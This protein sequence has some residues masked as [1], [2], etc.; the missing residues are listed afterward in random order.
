MTCDDPDCQKELLKIA[1]ISRV[2]KVESDKKKHE[3]IKQIF[4][5][6]TEK[7]PGTRAHHPRIIIPGLNLK[8]HKMRWPSWSNECVQDDDRTIYIL[9]YVKRPSGVEENATVFVSSGI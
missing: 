1:G 9:N 5:V 6:S 4:K 8:D 2:A 3:E 7:K